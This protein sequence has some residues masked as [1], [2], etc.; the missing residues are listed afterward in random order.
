MKIITKFYF[1]KSLAQYWWVGD[2]RINTVSITEESNGGNQI[3]TLFWR[4]WHR[5]VIRNGG[6]E[7]KFWEGRISNVLYE[8]KY[9]MW[10]L[11]LVRLKHIH[12]KFFILSNFSLENRHN[13]KVI[14]TDTI[15][16]KTSTEIPRFWGFHFY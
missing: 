2:C 11:L 1:I 16:W 7:E 14:K 13:S 5:T 15:T 10:F 8:Q 12:W 4:H 9:F 6:I 3:L